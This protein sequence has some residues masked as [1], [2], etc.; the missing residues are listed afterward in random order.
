[1][2]GE[3]RRLGLHGGHRLLLGQQAHAALGLRDGAEP[4]AVLLR[5]APR[6]R[7]EPLHVAALEFELQLAHGRGALRGRAR[8]RDD[9]ADVQ[10]HL[11]HGAGRAAHAQVAREPHDVGRLAL[12]QRHRA[13]VGRLQQAGQPLADGRAGVARGV[14]GGRG[15][16]GAQVDVVLEPVQRVVAGGLD[17][18]HPAPALL[19]QPQHHAVGHEALVGG[20]E[21]AGLQARA[22]DGAAPQCGFDGLQAAGGNTEL[23]LDFHG[24]HDA[25]S[26][27]PQRRGAGRF[28]V[29]RKI[30]WTPSIFFD[31]FCGRRTQRRRHTPDPPF[32]DTGTPPWPPSR[33]S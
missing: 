20:V 25:R 31:I 11:D 30:M 29:R 5:P 24:V 23:E 4:Q 16:A 27:F 14:D 32:I 12:D 19:A 3:T 2:S 28:P 1:M 9:L 15:G 33:S 13:A 17:G 21:I 26:F 22:H 6:E 8:V 18:L 10:R 7:H